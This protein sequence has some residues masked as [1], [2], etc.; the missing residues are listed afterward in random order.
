[1]QFYDYLLHK[2]YFLLHRLR[3]DLLE[4][5][6]AFSVSSKYYMITNG[7]SL[8]V[9]CTAVSAVTCDKTWQLSMSIH[10]K[11]LSYQSEYY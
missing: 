4:G 2:K 9:A 5:H 10:S 7:P 3:L 1:M 6:H 8:E 11:V